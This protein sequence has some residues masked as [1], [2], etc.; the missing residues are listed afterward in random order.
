[1]RSRQFGLDHHW[2]VKVDLEHREIERRNTKTSIAVNNS[3]CTNKYEKLKKRLML[4]KN[5]I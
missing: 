4:D 5:I 2:L 3:S 1:M